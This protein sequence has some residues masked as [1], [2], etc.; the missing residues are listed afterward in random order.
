MGLAEKALLWAKNKLKFISVQALP[1]IQKYYCICKIISTFSPF[2]LWNQFPEQKEKG[3]TIDPIFTQS[4]LKDYIYGF[5]LHIYGKCK[6][7]LN[8]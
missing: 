5:K 3:L 8:H 4:T 2:G 6:F 7:F 1:N